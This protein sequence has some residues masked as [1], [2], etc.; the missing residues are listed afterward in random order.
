MNL[1]SV[2]SKKKAYTRS[3]NFNHQIHSQR[4]SCHV[5]SDKNNSSLYHSVAIFTHIFNTCQGDLGQF[6]K[7]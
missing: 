3:Q 5:N 6:K 1:F 7:L 2:N 4:E